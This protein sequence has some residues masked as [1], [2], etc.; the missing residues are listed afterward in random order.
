M[1]LVTGSHIAFSLL[2]LAGGERERERALSLVLSPYKETRATRPEPHVYSLILLP[3]SRL[4]HQIQSHADSGFHMCIG[5]RGVGSVHNTGT[6]GHLMQRTD[7]L[8]RP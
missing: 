1:D 6:Y 4:Y 5:E 7:S 3:P 2:E 8:E